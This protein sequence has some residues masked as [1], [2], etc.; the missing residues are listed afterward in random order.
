MEK[1]HDK[2][3]KRKERKAGTASGRSP[4]SVQ[5]RQ[6]TTN[7]TLATHPIHDCS[8]ET[9]MGANRNAFATL[10]LAAQTAASPAVHDAGLVSSCHTPTA[11]WRPDTT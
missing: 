9:T 4:S 2:A 6:A 10:I 8:S 11:I 7:D 5:A 3:E 1:E